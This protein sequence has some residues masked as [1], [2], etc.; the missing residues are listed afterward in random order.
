MMEDREPIP[1]EDA[2]RCLLNTSP[3]HRGQTPPAEAEPTR[4]E[5]EPDE[6]PSE[7][8]EES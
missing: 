1:L 7:E 6:A 3:K 5:E 2:L 4:P 8:A